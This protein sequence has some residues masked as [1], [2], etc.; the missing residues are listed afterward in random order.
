VSRTFPIELDRAAVQTAYR[1]HVNASLGRLLGFMGAPVEMRSAGA[2]VFGDDDASYLDAGGY[3]VFLLGHC[4]P[5]VVSA[6]G[7]QLQTHPLSTRVMFNG[8]LA[9]AAKKL[10]EVSPPGLQYITFT[11]SGAEAVE[12]GL[13]LARL[14]GCRRIV[15]TV[16]GFH[17]KTMGAL[18]ATGSDSYRR[19]FLP[20]LPEVEHVAFGDADAMERA[21]TA[22]ATPTCVILEPVQAEGGVVFPP[23]GYLRRVSELCAAGRVF[24]IIDEIQT[25]LGRLGRWWGIDDQGVSPD[26]LLVG[27]TLSGGAVP[28]GAAVAT[29]GAFEPFDRDPLLHTST[30]GGNPLATAAAL[31]ALNTI[32]D[33]GLVDRARVLGDRLLCELRE[34]VEELGLQST[35]GIR[36]EGLLI[37]VEFPTS[38]LAMTWVL[39]LLERN[40]LVSHSLNAHQVVR[41]TPPAIM[42]DDQCTWLISAMRGAFQAM[43]SRLRN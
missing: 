21:L 7:R 33:E 42:T 24:L 41:L 9:A 30:F 10:A 5:A 15:A 4:H 14:A 32:C 31:A 11:N 2:L 6:V 39:E 27:K 23:A 22:A 40:V 38:Q 12:V 26:V 13:K 19:P 25:G 20:L 35:V 34:T 43:L 1:D 3:G 8:Q 17:G 37:G 16:G 18:S 36:G 29:P 28:I